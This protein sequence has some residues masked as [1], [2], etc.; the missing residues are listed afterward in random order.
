MQ[1]RLVRANPCKWFRYLRRNRSVVRHGQMISRFKRSRS[2]KKLHGQRFSGGFRNKIFRQSLRF[3]ERDIDPL[4]I[5]SGLRTR[6]SKILEKRQ[7]SGA[8]VGLFR[9]VSWR[10]ARSEKREAR[11]EKRE[12]RSGVQRRCA[13]SWQAIEMSTVGPGTGGGQAACFSATRSDIRISAKTSHWQA[14]SISREPMT[15]KPGRIGSHI[16]ASTG[17]SS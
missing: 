6:L 3:D 8:K 12:A 7:N 5:S 14:E 10:E 2:M 9:V 16:L 1:G 11:G 17:L 15:R 13:G 4:R